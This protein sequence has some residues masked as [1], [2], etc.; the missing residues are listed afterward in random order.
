MKTGLIPSP[1]DPDT[2]APLLLALAEQPPGDS[3][4]QIGAG[5]K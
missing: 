3:T 2:Q 5:N 4:P 1:G